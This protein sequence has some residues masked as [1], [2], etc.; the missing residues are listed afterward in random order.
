MVGIKNSGMFG[1][2]HK[3]SSRLKMGLKQKGKIISEYQKKQISIAMTGF[4]HTDIAKYKISLS[5]R[6]A[7]NPA[8]RGGISDINCR[9]RRSV[10]Y[11]NW[12]ESVFKRDN[13]TC[14]WCGQHGG[15][16]NADHIKPFSL[17]P[18]ER[19]NIDNGRVLCEDCHK[20]TD[21]YKKKALCYN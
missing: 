14:I 5:K 1:K 7:N 4:K 3:L 19:F 9:I 12:R 8:W 18:E 20:K 6:G 11:K 2:K 16:L 21:T 10:E 15:R 17:F 13:Y